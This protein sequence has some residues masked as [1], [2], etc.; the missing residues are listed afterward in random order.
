M[1]KRQIPAFIEPQLSKLVDRPPAQAGWAHEVKFDGY[2]AQLRVKSGSAVIRTRKGLDWTD[3]FGA[4]AKQGA[5]LPDCIIDGEIVALDEHQLPNF[6]A[7][8]AALS[9]PIN[10]ERRDVRDRRGVERRA[11]DDSDKSHQPG[12]HETGAELQDPPP[13]AWR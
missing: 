4:V 12:D 5:G 2:R 13:E 8:Q 1:A 7:L 11:V 9:E 10:Q 6:G 3:R